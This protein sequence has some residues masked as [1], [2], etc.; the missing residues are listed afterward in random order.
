M[1]LGVDLRQRE[2]RPPR[3]YLIRHP[4][5][6]INWVKLRYSRQLEGG[7]E[8]ER[9]RGRKRERERREVSC[10]STLISR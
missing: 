6:A 9:E 1:R 4:N 5:S 2:L 3:C 10:G 7:G 8:R